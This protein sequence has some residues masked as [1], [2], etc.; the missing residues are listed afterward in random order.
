[1]SNL[2]MPRIDPAILH[3]DRAEWMAAVAHAYLGVYH[4]GLLHI[5]KREKYFRRDEAKRALEKLARPQIIRDIKKMY[6][7]EKGGEIGKTIRAIHQRLKP[8]S[9]NPQTK[10]LVQNANT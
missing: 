5:L 7:L 9:Y 8:E 4:N 6:G 10:R 3:D 2:L 1:M